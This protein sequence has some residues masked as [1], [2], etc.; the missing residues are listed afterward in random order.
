MARPARGQVVEYGA[1]GARVFA[2]RFRAYG[3][4]EYVTLGS[5]VEGWTRARAQAELENVLADVR[6]GIWQPPAPP[7]VP[8]ADPTFHE[9]ASRWLSDRTPELRPR[10]LE[11]YTWAL[12]SHLLPFFHR[13]R[14]SEI[15]IAEVDRYR[16]QKLRERALGPASLN[17]TITR[18]AQILDVA[19]E[20]HP[21]LI[22]GNPAR[23]RRR[24]V[25]QPTPDRGFL[26]AEQLAALLEAAG[27]LDARARHDRAHVGRRAMLAVLA[28]GGLRISELIE[29]RWRDVDLANGRL[30]VRAAKTDAGS[31]TVQVGGLL[32]DELLAHKARSTTAG[33]E[34]LVFAT[35]TGGPQNRNNVRRRV[36]RPAI[37]RANQMLI[38]A[39]RPPI[40][41]NVTLHALRRT[42]ISLL[43]ETGENPRVVMA[44]VGH[45]DPGL[46]L[47][48]Y[49]QVMRQRETDTTKLDDLIRDHDWAEMGRNALRRPPAPVPPADPG[50]KNPSISRPNPHWAVLGSNQRPPACKAGAL[51]S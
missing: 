36:L 14:L 1:K 11:D 21:G 27:A 50:I 30:H 23:G 18:L 22:A 4:R 9:F 45:A 17:K 3:R 29:L 8:P 31:R 37:E 5:S 24:R 10:T 6:R 46:T 26:E 20:H 32:R 7:P 19:I 41:G 15:T 51:T 25:R 16:A 2:L 13:H 34:R 38:A 47:R 39:G 49:A 43:L 40:P 12:T 44:Q 42:Y 28:L 35:A 33:P 48:L